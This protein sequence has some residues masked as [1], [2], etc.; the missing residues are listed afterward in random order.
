MQGVYAV[1]YRNGHEGID[2]CTAHGDKLAH[3]E[4]S[5]SEGLIRP[6]LDSLG[7]QLLHL[8]KKENEGFKLQSSKG[9]G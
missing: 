5:H 8:R 3:G 7:E 2:L 4:G 9:N 1:I 6:Q